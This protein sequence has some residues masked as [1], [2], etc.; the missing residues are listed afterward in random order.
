MPSN[1]SSLVSM[2]IEL[3]EILINV[4]VFTTLQS[5]KDSL[6]IILSQ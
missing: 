3:Y 6:I 4:I 1:V 5:W 2:K